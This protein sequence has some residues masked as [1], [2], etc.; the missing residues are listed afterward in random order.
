MSEKSASSSKASAPIAKLQDLV[1]LRRN[2]PR[3][4]NRSPRKEPVHTKICQGI[5]AKIVAGR[6]RMPL[7]EVKSIIEEYHEVMAETLRN[8][9]SVVFGKIGTV[10]P[11]RRT[12]RSMSPDSQ[13]PSVRQVLAFKF[14]AS[15]VLRAYCKKHLVQIKERDADV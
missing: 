1:T 4:E 11:V 2:A 10:R 5:A 15:P 3:A 8:G 7:S 12:L 13:E 6:L 14:T 9:Q